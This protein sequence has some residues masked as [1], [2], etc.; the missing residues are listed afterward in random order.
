[1]WLDACSPA[2]YLQLLAGRVAAFEGYP[3]AEID[4]MPIRFVVA[5][6]QHV[7]GETS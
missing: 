3:S 7:G 2:C 1:V 5:L 4:E 6:L